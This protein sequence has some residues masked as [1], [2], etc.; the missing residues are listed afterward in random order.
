M[1]KIQNEELIKDSVVFNSLGSNSAIYTHIHSYFFALWLWDIILVHIL[2]LDSST[3]GS[4]KPFMMDYFMRRQNC[5][6]VQGITY[7]KSGYNP[8][9]DHPWILV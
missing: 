5:T 6:I 8:L 9:P 3:L 7:I 4:D 2:A 1:E